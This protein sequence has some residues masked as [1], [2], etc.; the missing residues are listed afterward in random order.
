MKTLLLMRH[1]EASTGVSTRLSDNQLALTLQGSDDARRMAR[2]LPRMGTVPQIITCSAAKR[3]ALTATIMAQIL[4]HNPVT[5]IAALYAAGP[6]R[7]LEEVQLLPGKVEVA[8][9]VGHNP[10]ISRLAQL[11]RR[12]GV[13]GGQFIPGGLACLE[14][15]AQSWGDIRYHNG[16]CKWYL[17]PDTAG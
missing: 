12:E 14:F 11:L 1:C 7:Y 3:A 5:A 6:E 10:A 4:G 15:T 13:A 8:L 2:A 17:T 9:M 16:N